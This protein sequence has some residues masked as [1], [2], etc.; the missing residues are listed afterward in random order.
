[1]KTLA[2]LGLLF[3]TLRASDGGIVLDVKVDPVTAGQALREGDPARF[4]LTLT[5][6]STGT[7]LA[8]VFP[9]AWFALDP[10][11]KEN[12]RQNC[13][14]SVA[15]FAGGNML[16]RPALSLNAYY[17][18]ALNSDATVTVVDPHFGF[19]GTQLLGMVALPAPGFDWSLGSND[20]RLF[21]TVPKT[22]QVAV[23]DTHSWKLLRTIDV[24]ADPRRIV[25][26]EDGHY[27][28]ITNEAGVVAMRASDQT[29][30]AAI[31][32]GKG[33]HD[34]VV[35]P[36]NRTVIVTNRDDGTATLIDVA[37]LKVVA[38]GPVGPKPVSIAFSELSQLAYVASEEGT[39]S[40]LDPKRRK[41]VAAIKTEPG[42]ERVRFAPGGRHGFTLNPSKNL[43]HI[44]D[45]ASNKIIQT[46]QL[47]GEP[48]EVTFTDTLAYIRRR[49]SEIVLMV[50]L[51][52]I[53]TTGKQIAVVDFP[54]GDKTFGA[55]PRTTVADG[56]VSTPGMSAVLVANPADEHVYFYKEG[57]AAP[58]GH[59]KNYGH[60]P[61]AVL[62]VD[63]SLRERK[64]G[65]FSTTATMP[66]AGTYD[67]AVF[68]PSPRAVACFTVT[69][70]ENPALPNKNRMPVIVE[71]LTPPETL[72]VGAPARLEF[73]LKDA[74]TNQPALALKDAGALI[75]QVNGAWSER[76][77]LVATGDGHYTMAFVPPAKGVYYI[78]VEAPSMG[79]KASNPQFLVLSAN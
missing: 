29:V 49:A 41:L 66:R 10:H 31:A 38:N 46:G 15:A 64:P 63:R 77:R 47:E 67:I 3:S 30:A 73:R 33:A 70:A 24:G 23:I 21:V 43:L 9:S 32:T 5:N 61:Q 34:L 79:L 39:I 58:S 40:A 59:F 7:P 35:T 65:T 72:E 54:A 20:D 45:V 2:I 16:T 1:M 6:E 37:T 62:V 52:A 27:L 56:I 76:Q 48:F 26:Q 42:L 11:Q 68:V 74:K 60:E 55:R 4:A 22:N 44:F 13:T 51:A 50:P 25:A 12:N 28:W 57:M 8:G 69:I 53:G 17:V 14:A 71:H 19:G 18:V 78:Y 36:D 75:M